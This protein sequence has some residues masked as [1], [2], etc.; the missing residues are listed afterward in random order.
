MA[1]PTLTDVARQVDVSPETLRRW[2]REEIV[3]LREG[4]WTRAAIAH[5]RIVAR[6]R[7]RG[8][9]LKALREG[10]RPGDLPGLPA[11][12]LTAAATH[13]ADYKRWTRDFLGGS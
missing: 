4:R 13:D 6:L 12:A 5:A 1:D 3:P 10:T 9:P 7:A 11:P 2:V 8:Y